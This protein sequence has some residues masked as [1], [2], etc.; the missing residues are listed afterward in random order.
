MTEVNGNTSPDTPGPSSEDIIAAAVGEAY[1][2]FARE[3]PAT[4][5]VLQ[6]RLKNPVEFIMEGLKRDAAYQALVAQ[7]EEELSIAAILKVVIPAVL[8]IVTTIIGVL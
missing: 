7:T 1:E 3:H 5:R 4:A 8:Q 6:K 2:H